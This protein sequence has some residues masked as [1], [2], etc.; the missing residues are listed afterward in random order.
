MELATQLSKREL[1][2]SKR[3]SELALE[4]AVAAGKLAVVVVV[5]VVVAEKDEK[6]Y[7]MKLA[8]KDSEILRSRG[9][10][11]TRGIVEYYLKDA[12]AEM[13]LKETFNARTACEGIK[14]FDVN[15]SEFAPTTRRLKRLASECAF[16]VN[17]LYDMHRELSD[18][19]HGGSWSGPALR[20]HS[21]NT[22]PKY[23][24]FIRSLAESTYLYADEVD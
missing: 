9:T 12:A 14:N 1:E 18:E 7:A 23:G 8:E 11:T 13:R 2:L 22:P 4:V 10:V 19:I 17:N 15:S 6:L 3:E 21:K 20:Y 5:V 24:A 16:E